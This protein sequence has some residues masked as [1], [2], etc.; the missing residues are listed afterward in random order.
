MPDPLPVKESGPAPRRH[1]AFAISVVGAVAMVILSLA[2]L[3][4]TNHHMVVDSNRSDSVQ[5]L[6]AMPPLT[7]RDANALLATAPSYKALMNELAL[8]PNNATVSRNKQSAFAVLDKEK[9]KL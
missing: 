7:M 9:T 3:R 2:G 8:R 5:P 1:F 4:I 6:R